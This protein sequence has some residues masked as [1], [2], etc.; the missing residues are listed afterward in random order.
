M[1]AL[2]RDATEG[3][4][5]EQSS[6]EGLA[7]GLC[8]VRRANGVDVPSAI[9]MWPRTPSMAQVASISFADVLAF[10]TLTAASL[11]DWPVPVR[12]APRGQLHNRA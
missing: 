12:T 1:I 6:D 10:N 5:V 11:A 4:F 9:A 3:Q 2:V 8:R 7:E